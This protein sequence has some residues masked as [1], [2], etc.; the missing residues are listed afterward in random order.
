MSY[1]PCQSPSDGGIGGRA[2][3]TYRAQNSELRHLQN[4]LNRRLG[5]VR[6]WLS[7]QRCSV[8]HGEGWM[9]LIQYVGFAEDGG[10]WDDDDNLKM[11]ELL[12]PKLRLRN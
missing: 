7:E 11:L 4:V 3:G 8:C 1:L 9:Y 6:R 2:G 5:G 12:T 10:C